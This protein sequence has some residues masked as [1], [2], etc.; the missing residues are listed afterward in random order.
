[1][2]IIAWICRAILA[3]SYWWLKKGS[4]IGIQRILRTTIFNIKKMRRNIKGIPL[5]ILFFMKLYIPKIR[6]KVN[7]KDTKKVFVLSII[8]RSMTPN[9]YKYKTPNPASIL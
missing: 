6:R 9:I 8:L 4:G 7:T 1:M 3:L 5:F 2:G